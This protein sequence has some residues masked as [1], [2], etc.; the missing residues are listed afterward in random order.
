MLSEIINNCIVMN[1]H[2]QSN[3]ADLFAI[4]SK[5]VKIN[6][7]SDGTLF[8][9]IR[10]AISLLQSKSRRRKKSFP[11]SLWLHSQKTSG[12][13]QRITLVGIKMDTALPNQAAV[14]SSAPTTWRNQKFIHQYSGIVSSSC[15]LC[16]GYSCFA[17]SSP[18][19]TLS[20]PC[21]CRLHQWN[22][23]M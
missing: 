18:K 14:D 16:G 8:L 21:F 1:I 9:L 22:N 23:S 12:H 2:K 5:G 20:I 7:S 13:V 15:C 10:Y 11:H 3:R 17:L 4:I 6:A 19:R